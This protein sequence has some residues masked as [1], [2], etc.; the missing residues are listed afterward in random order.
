MLSTSLTW[1]IHFICV[2]FTIGVTVTPINSR[3]AFPVDAALTLLRAARD[4]AVADGE[5]LVG[6]VHAVAAPVAKELEGDASRVA[7]FEFVTTTK[8]RRS[9]CGDVFVFGVT[10]TLV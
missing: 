5:R 3:Y 8:R 9:F 10:V 2:V 4:G 6:A 1:T 7:T